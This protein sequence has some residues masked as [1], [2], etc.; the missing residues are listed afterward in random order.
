M[1]FEKSAPEKEETEAS[2]GQSVLPQCCR[3]AKSRRI[4]QSVVPSLGGE[5]TDLSEAVL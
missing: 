1:P 5:G 2:G 3:C 4:G